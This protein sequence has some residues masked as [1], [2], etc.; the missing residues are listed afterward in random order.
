M[1]IWRKHSNDYRLYAGSRLMGEVMPDSKHP[2]MWRSTMSG[3][4]LSDMANITW[5]KEAVYAAAER[6]LEYEHH[7]EAA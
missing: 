7:H 4:R 6:E 2:S 1:L 3:G 5:A